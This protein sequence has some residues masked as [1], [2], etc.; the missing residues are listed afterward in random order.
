MIIMTAKWMCDV[1]LSDISKIGNDQTV[2][3]LAGK[4]GAGKT[5]VM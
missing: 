1:L 2:L 4:G 3:I 5:T